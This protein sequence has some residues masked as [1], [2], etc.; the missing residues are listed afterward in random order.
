MIQNQLRL[1]PL[2]E[3][4]LDRTSR[5]RT[6]LP[7]E[8]VLEL[9]QSIAEHGL[10]QNIGLNKDTME[11]IFGERRYTAFQLIARAVA[12]D[13]SLPITVS[14]PHLYDGWTKIPARLCGDV[15]AFGVGALEFIENSSRLD[16][17]WQDQGK[18]AWSLHQLAVAEAKAREENWSEAQ[19]A[20]LLGVSPS[21]LN[22]L[23]TPFRVLESSSE[24]TR[25]AIE[26]AIQ[27][28]PSALSA[29][30]SVTAIKERHG[31]VKPTRRSPL[32]AAKVP[33]APPPRKIITAPILNQS[34][35]DWAP[36]WDGEPFNFIHCDFPYGIQFNKGGGQN[37]SAATKSVGQ[38]DDNPEV[39]WKLLRAL[40]ENRSR[41]VSP[42]AHIMFWF[43]QNFR[44]ETEDRIMEAWP[45][46][47]ISKFL[48]IWHCPD[49]SGLMPSPAEGRR[50][51]ETAL[52]ITLGKRPL[53]AG[54]AMSISMPRNESKIHRSQKHLPVLSH[55]F[56]MYID[57]SSRVLDP[58]VGSATSLVA[59]K[60]L[61]ASA[62]L[63][64]EIDPEMFEL[65]SKFFSENVQ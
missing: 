7:P 15:S 65:A 23:I 32:I 24:K 54:K 14:D 9:A 31:E 58:T 4:R 34:F 39:Y 48:L 42:S 44:R 51:Y 10:L 1:V 59:A 49:N 6:D 3:V 47:T 11:I 28:S 45:D 12:G 21:H 38:Y 33:A 25:P 64:L 57:G 35:L 26:Q 52:Q 46:A 8:S 2:T 17:P 18:A 30:N 60:K 40:L 50:T 20:A 56:S 5:Q 55:F 63:G 22:R 62:V 41:L 43:S 27:A 37:T 36:A 29:N 13:P 61:G 16:L 19:T 53:A